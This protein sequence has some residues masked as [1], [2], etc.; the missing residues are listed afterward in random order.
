[1]PNYPIPAG[2]TE[3]SISDPIFIIPPPPPQNQSPVVNVGSDI[4]ITLPTN[5]VVLSGVASDPDG[6]IVSS[7]WSQVAGGAAVIEN[8][9]SVVTKISGLT[10]GIYTFRLKVTDNKGATATDDTNVTVKAAIPSTSGYE[11]FGAVTTGGD[12]FPV[13]HVTTLNPTGAG[14]LSSAM[15]NNRKI[16]VDV[17]GIINGFRFTGTNVANLTIEGNGITINGNAG[18]IFAFEDDCHDFI[19]KNIRFGGS[20][21]EDAITITNRS[22]RFIIDHCSL[23]TPGTTG[24][25]GDGLIDITDGAH[26][27]TVQFCWFGKNN[28]NG[29]QLIDYPNTKNISIHHNLYE[30]SFERNP[31]IGSQ[32][33]ANRTD[34]VCDFVNNVVLNWSNYGT[35]VNNNG[36]ANIRNNYYESK[37][38]PGN[39][40]QT[41]N[42]WGGY[43]QGFAYV[44]GNVSGNGINIDQASNHALWPVPAAAQ[45]TMQD[46]RTAANKV[47]AQCGAFPRLPQEQALIDSI[48][49]K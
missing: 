37:S 8:P 19:L 3:V 38:N 5:N 34:L 28:T 30:G 22:N 31:L 42:G 13:V 9:D 46:A 47:L 4:T 12:N 18:S 39:A 43:P 6:V 35:D 48:T 49:I 41:K 25:I 44:N 10:E 27:G 29:A 17:K 33:A 32:N 11:G 45:V 40:V 7:Q 2:A 24:K 26:D 1:M 16:M 20:P 36:T 15:G 14:S 21:G 23:A